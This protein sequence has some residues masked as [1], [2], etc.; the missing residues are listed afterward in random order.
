M[1]TPKQ[2]VLVI[3]GTGAQGTPVVKELSK[4]NNY[5]IHVLTRSPTSPS[6]LA[7]SSLPNVTIVPG[8]GYNET[9]LH[10]AFKNIS[11]AFVNLNGFAIGEKAE[12]YWGIRL[13]EIASEHG[14]QHFIWAS[15]DSSY[16][17]SGYQPRFRTGHFDGKAKVADWISGQEGG[18]KW[19]VLTSCMY[20]E[21]FAEMLAPSKEMV[22]GEEVTVFKAP[23]GRGTPPMIYLE[24]LGRYARWIVENPERSVGLNL[25]IATANVG[26]EDVARSFTEVTGRKAVFRDLSLEEY[27]ASG[28]FGDADRKVGHSVGFDDE[29]LQTYRENFS[30]F[31]NTWKED[32][33]KRSEK[34]YELLDEILPER[35]RSVGE[36]MKLTGYNGERGNVLKDYADAGRKKPQ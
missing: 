4:T 16:K 22:E 12:L 1:S 3:G 19:S 24:D 32:V 26:W 33:L 21:T 10:S 23:V 34:D 15:L 13:F 5:T 11:I 29:T 6:V 2:T 7:L 18:M 36:W 31:W 28:V 14:V 20:L 27:F 35:V 8:D 9:T 25:R 30:G 17:L